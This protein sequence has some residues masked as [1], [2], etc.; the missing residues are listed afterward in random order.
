[1][2]QIREKVNLHVSWGF[3]GFTLGRPCVNSELAGSLLGFEG[4][5]VMTLRSPISVRD[6]RLAGHVFAVTFGNFQNSTEREL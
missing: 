2:V 6:N 5:S 1:V 4:R 3:C